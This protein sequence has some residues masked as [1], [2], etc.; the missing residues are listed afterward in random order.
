[1]LVFLILKSPELRQSW[2][3]NLQ[4][5]RPSQPQPPFPSPL[6]PRC[7][8]ARCPARARQYM[9]YFQPGNAAD[10]GLSELSFMVANLQA[11]VQYIDSGRLLPGGEARPVMSVRS[12]PPP[13]PLLL[14]AA[15]AAG[16]PCV[17]SGARHHDAHDAKGAV[18][19]RR[20]LYCAR[21]NTQGRGAFRA[22]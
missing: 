10:V 7:V 20:T 6:R 12:P 18:R 16:P 11:A 9:H 22:L 8:T 17:H 13:L 1:M 21:C 15:P 19:A 5:R 2:Y 4:V 3:A 14:T